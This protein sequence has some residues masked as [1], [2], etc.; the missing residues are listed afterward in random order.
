MKP[1]TFGIKTAPQH[2]TYDA[3]LQ[4]WQQT[5]TQ[6]ITTFEGRYYQ[7]KD[8]RREPKPVQKPHLL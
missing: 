4:I 3:I 8:A 6:E 1:I 7:L 2:T 5:D